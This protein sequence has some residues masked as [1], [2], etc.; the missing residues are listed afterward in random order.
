MVFHCEIAIRLF[1]LLPRLGTVAAPS[2]HRRG[3]PGRMPFE[4]IW[5]LFDKIEDVW[6]VFNKN[7]LFLISF[8]WNLMIFDDFSMHFRSN[9]WFLMIFQWHLSQTYQQHP[10]RT[11]ENALKSMIYPQNPLKRSDIR[12]F[13][14]I[15][16]DFYDF[17][18][19]FDDFW[20]IFNTIWC[21]S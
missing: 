9:W 15:S 2:R 19:K 5:W 20:W 17:S 11:V 14:L 4:D 13:L 10:F 21:T 12:W 1:V 6:W 18:M 7:W 8:R 16:D 3:F